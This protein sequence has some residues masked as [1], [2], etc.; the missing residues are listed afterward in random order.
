MLFSKPPLPERIRRIACVNFGGIGDEILFAP[1]LEAIKQHLPEAHVTLLLESRSQVVTDLLA[2]ADETVGLTIQGQSRF[3]SFKSL[4]KALREGRFDAVISSGSNPFIPVLLA[5][6]GIPIRVGFDPAAPTRH[7]LTVAAPLPPKAE[8]TGYAAEMYFAL[9]RSFLAWLLPDYTPPATILP[10]LK[11]PALEDLLWAKSLLQPDDPRRKILL[12]PGVS[13][14]SVR[15]NILKSWSP[16]AWAELTC[17]LSHAGHQLF[18]VGGPDDYDAVDAIKSVLP[19]DLPNFHNLFGQTKSLKRLAALIQGCDL[20]IGVDS[21]PMHIAVGYGKP[22]VA[23]FGPTDEKTLLPPHD[24]RFR[25]VTLPNLTCRPCLWAVR[26]ESC[27]QPT[28]LNVPVPL[29]LAAVEAA[30]SLRRTPG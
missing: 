6:S 28:C 20:L 19:D 3:N 30:L 23:M 22:V 5:S 26:D 12:H 2:H 16:H 27:A 10:H 4:R 29:M 13:L 25:A 7:L 14:V 24:P 18:L 15:K 9:A 1:V 17:L 21:S 8:R 11:P